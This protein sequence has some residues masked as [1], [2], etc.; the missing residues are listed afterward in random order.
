MQRLALGAI[1]ANAGIIV[2]GGAVRLSNSG[3]GCPTWPKCTDG[4]L[5]PGGG[6][7]HGP[8]HQGIEFSNR[9][10]TF[11]VF[12]AAVLCVLGAW[13]MRPRRRGLLGIAWILPAGIVLQAVLG[14][15]TVLDKL[16]PL[17]VATH[18]LPSPVLCYIAVWLYVR[19]GE[20]DGPPKLAVRREIQLGVRF[21]VVVVA[22]VEVVGT[23]VTATGPHAGDPH[24][25]RLDWDPKM[26]TQF[27]ADLVFLY[28]GLLVALILGL[29]ATRAGRPV[30][31]RAYV[32]AGVVVLQAAIG[33]VQYFTH[34]PAVLVGCHMAGAALAVIATARLFFAT[35]TRD[36]L[37]AET[38]ELADA[39]LIATR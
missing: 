20:G 8:I 1:V 22:A 4:R 23:L 15:I 11:L 38:T 29:K 31:V 18:F 19:A 10:L 25:K 17:T 32:L 33:Y 37:P 2:T 24:T 13:R 36:A 26:V 21:L 7:T 5:L 3:L 39:A 34:V 35:R 28:V 14:G 9:L 12:A 6:N 30:I 16:N 27:H